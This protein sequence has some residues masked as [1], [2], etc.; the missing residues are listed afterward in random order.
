MFRLWNALAVGSSNE[1]I[2]LVS[3]ATAVAFRPDGNELAVAT[4][5]GHITFFD[6]RTS[7]QTG[8]IE[9]RKDLGSGR[10]DAD[11]ITAKKSLEV[12]MLFSALRA[13]A[14]PT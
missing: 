1:S 5:N 6:A 10:A 4:L 13:V 3:D 14:V 8:A 7:T 2:P 11:L 12:R 9:G